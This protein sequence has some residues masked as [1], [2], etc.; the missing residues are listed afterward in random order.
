MLARLLE[1]PRLRERGTAWLRIMCGNPRQT[2]I[3]LDRCRLYVSLLDTIRLAEPAKFENL[4]QIAPRKRLI[5][6]VRRLNSKRRGK[7]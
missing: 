6:L 2:R 1:G 3:V 4:L 7:Q 5:I